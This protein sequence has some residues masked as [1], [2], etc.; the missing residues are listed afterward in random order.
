MS[1]PIT[2][3]VGPMFISYLK[4][5]GGKRVMNHHWLNVVFLDGKPS[6]WHISGIFWH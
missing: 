5:I 3:I 1:E 2:S 6:D 4:P